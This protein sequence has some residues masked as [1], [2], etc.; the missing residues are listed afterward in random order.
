MTI[1]RR[2]WQQVTYSNILYGLLFLY[3]LF[4][5]VVRHWSTLFGLIMIPGIV[6][7]FTQRRKDSIV[8]HKYEKIFLWLLVGNFSVFSLTSLIHLPDDIRDIQLDIEVLFLLMIPLYLL[9]SLAIF[10][11]HMHKIRNKVH[12]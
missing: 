3:P 2:Y 11:N 12:G 5:T 7:F 9:L 4:A 1:I 10:Q 8:L 6:Y